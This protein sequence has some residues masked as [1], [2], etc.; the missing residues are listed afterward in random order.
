[1]TGVIRQDD[2]LVDVIGDA[3]GEAKADGGEVPEWGAR[4]IARALANERDDPFNGALHHFAVTGRAAP[5]AMAQELA[6]LYERTT[7]EEIREW[8]NWLG[9]YVINLP[10]TAGT[11]SEV[12]TTPDDNSHDRDA[13]DNISEH[14]ENACEADARGEPIST[15]DAKAIA[16]QLARLLP[17]G[18]EMGRFA[19]TGDANPVVISEE[20]WFIQ[21]RTRNTPDIGTW[22]LSFA[23]YLAAQASLGRQAEPPSLEAGQ[24]PDSLMIRYGIARHGDAFRAYLSLPDIDPARADLIK[25][26]RDFYVGTYDSM[27]DLITDLVG[28]IH[29]EAELLELAADD[30]SFEELVHAT[31]DIVEVNGKFYA[32]T[33]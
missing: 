27:D 25:S 28:G 3:I 10:D 30:I 1:M 11:S 18:S 15:D 12:T 24:L 9:T 26:F 16:A 20:C 22:A 17:P 4:T 21:E 2:A 29:S 31:W 6:E 7:Y 23:H 5:E 32:F 8:I 19:A 13:L 33:K 14:L